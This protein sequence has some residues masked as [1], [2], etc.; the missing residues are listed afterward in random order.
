MS[1]IEN[2]HEKINSLNLAKEEKTKMMSN[3][4]DQKAKLEIEKKQKDELVKKLIKDESKIKAAVIKKNNEAKELNAQI[5]KIIEKVS[6]TKN[7]S[8]TNISPK[9]D[10]PIGQSRT[11]NSKH[12]HQVKVQ[13]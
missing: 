5:Q 6:I 10:L 1:T 9:T 4:K 12:D 11:P 3:E 7:S 2:L 8:L 13:S